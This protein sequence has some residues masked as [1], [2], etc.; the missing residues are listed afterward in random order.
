MVNDLR[1]EYV[2]AVEGV[3]R[4]RPS[5]AVNKK[6]KTGMV[7]VCLMQFVASY[8]FIYLLF[9]SLSHDPFEHEW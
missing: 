8:T 9:A 4:L 2:I 3:V 6:M 1:L 7:E 5:E